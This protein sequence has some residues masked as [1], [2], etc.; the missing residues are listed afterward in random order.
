MS[1]EKPNS[2]ANYSG[3][4]INMVLDSS[5][6][7]VDCF[8]CG[9]KSHRVALKKSE[10]ALCPRCD[11]CVDQS[12]SSDNFQKA[13]IFAIA[14]LILLIPSNIFPVLGFEL[15]GVVYYTTFF[16]S[17]VV[18]YNQGFGI[19]SVIIVLTGIIFPIF[20]LLTI[21]TIVLDRYKLINILQKRELFRLY[22]FLK[23]GSFIDVFLLAILIAYIKLIDISN[24]IFGNSLFLFIGAVIFYTL[25]KENLNMTRTHIFLKEVPNSINISLALILTGFILFI[26][27]NILPIME[28]STLGIVT[29]DTIFSGVVSLVENEMI[30]IGII[31][32]TASIG[33]PLF[34]ILGMLYIILSVKFSL[35]RDK[36]SILK[37]YKIIEFIGKWSVL[38][39]YMIALMAALVKEESIAYVEAGVA[40]IYFALVVFITIFATE[41]FDTK[42]I[43][44]ENGNSKTTK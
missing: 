8:Y 41:A 34:K 3:Y 44:E 9:L 11:S 16:Q 36:R 13:L 6:K 29:K 18:L 15:N 26:P 7:F 1:N 4:N 35:K 23:I 27:S 43:W 42:L 17:G 24:V 39:I 5:L 19:L 37:L 21:I 32:F 2:F 20:H 10:V 30:P 38:D 14:S 33:I 40:S 31:V 12:F 22:L 28:I 25:S